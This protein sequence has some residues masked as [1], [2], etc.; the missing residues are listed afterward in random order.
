MVLSKLK[1]N[2]TG[3]LMVLLTYMMYYHGCNIY[4]F[5]YLIIDGD[6]NDDYNYD[7]DYDNDNDND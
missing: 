7:E 4:L 2:V 6:D 1:Y 3:R 5:I